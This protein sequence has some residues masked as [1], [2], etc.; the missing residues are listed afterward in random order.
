MTAKEGRAKNVQ[1]DI[2]AFLT[3]KPNLLTYLFQNGWDG[4]GKT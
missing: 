3:V 2:F 1:S 4:W